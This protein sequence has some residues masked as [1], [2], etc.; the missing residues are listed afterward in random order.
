MTGAEKTITDVRDD[1]GNF[2]GEAV[3]YDDMTMLALTCKGDHGG[4]TL[5][6]EATM[7]NWDPG[8]R[9]LECEP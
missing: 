9:F 4:E 1:I 5:T 7:E 6:L 8:M 3:R 2:V